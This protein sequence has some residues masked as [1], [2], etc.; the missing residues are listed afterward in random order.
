[1][2]SPVNSNLQNIARKAKCPDCEAEL[3][4]PHDIEKGEVLSCPCCVLELEVKKIANGGGCVDLQ[5][6]SIEGEDW[7]E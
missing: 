3:S 1:M 4:V 2:I 7:G 6:L 5:E